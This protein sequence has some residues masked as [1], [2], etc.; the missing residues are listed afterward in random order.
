MSPHCRR[1][2][3]LTYRTWA[4]W[5]V[6]SRLWE[7]SQWSG[8]WFW[9]WAFC[10]T[11]ENTFMS[12]DRHGSYSQ[13]CERV[14]VKPLHSN[15]A[16]SGLV[17]FTNYSR[18]K[19]FPIVVMVTMSQQSFCRRVPS[20]YTFHLIHRSVW[21]WN[22]S[23]CFYTPVKVGCIMVCKLPLVRSITSDSLEVI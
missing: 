22:G 21:V 2:Q 6:Q 5:E 10:W 13:S 11:P 1:L 20:R 9:F 18:S 19:M 3:S 17:S 7:R 15:T 16:A 23:V 14:A 12:Q 8:P 4:L